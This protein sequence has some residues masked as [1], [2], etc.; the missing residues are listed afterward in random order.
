MVINLRRASRIHRR[1]SLR[2][3]RDMRNGMRV[4]CF[5]NGQDVT[6]RCFYY[7]GRRKIVRLYTLNVA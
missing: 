7:D 3:A 5:L 1:V 4:R 2:N 6:S